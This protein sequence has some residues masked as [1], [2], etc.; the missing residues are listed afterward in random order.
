[1][2]TRTSLPERTYKGCR[3]RVKPETFGGGFYDLALERTPSGQ[4]IGMIHCEDEDHPL[5]WVT[6]GGI[7][8]PGHPAPTPAGALRNA[9]HEL[10]TL[11][12][13]SNAGRRWKRTR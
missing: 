6:H 1:M 3:I 11:L 2:R 9:K 12:S 5:R 7:G 10:N 4:Y 8:V 13:M